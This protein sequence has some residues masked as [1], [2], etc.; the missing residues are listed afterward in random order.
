MRKSILFLL[1]LIFSVLNKLNAQSFEIFGDAFSVPTVSNATCS[2]ADTCF[3]LTANANWQNGAVWDLDPIDLSQAFDATFCMFIGANDQGADGFA[4]VMRDPAANLYGED[5]GSL[6]YGSNDG[7]TGISPSVAIEFDSFYNP[8][9]FDI[10]EDHTA[11]VLNGV[12][13]VA[14]AVPSVPLLPNG[15]NVEDNN[16]HNARIVWNPATQEISMYFDGF[17]RFTYTNDI[18]NNV[19]NG[20]TEVLWGFTASTGGFSNLQQICFPKVLL[21]IPDFEICE[22]DSV[23][24]SY[25]LQNVQ[26][27]TWTNSDGDIIIDWNENMGVPLTQTSFYATE[28]GTYTLTVTF[29]N[30]VYSE[31]ALVTLIPLPEQVSIDLCESGENLN[32]FSLFTTILPTTGTWSGPS[33]LTGNHLGTFNPQTN[34]E[35]VYV[36]STNQTSICP[37]ENQVTINF[38]SINFNPTIDLI[39]C[40]ETVYE[41]EVNPLMS[42]GQTDFTYIWFSTNATLTSN[43]N[44]TEAEI[45]TNS[46]VA[47]QITSND[48]FACEFDTIINLVF[49]S[50]PQFNLGPDIFIC[51][52]ETASIDAF[53]NWDSYLWS[54]NSTNS[55]LTVSSS[56]V[57]WLEVSNDENCVFRDTIEVLVTEIPEITL[58]PFDTISCVPFVLSFEAELTV[59]QAILSWNFGDG[60]SVLNTLS[61]SHTYTS[62]GVYDLTLTASLGSS[63][64]QTLVVE[65]AIHVINRPNASFNYSIIEN[66]GNQITVEFSNNSS[67]YNQFFW[68]FNISSDSIEENPIVTFN[69]VDNSSFTII[70]NVSNGYCEDETSRIIKLPSQ[71]IYYVPNTFTPDGNNFNNVFEPIFTEGILEDSY[72]LSIYNRWG[73][74]VF[75]SF[76]S[77]IGWDGTYGSRIA[78]EGIY[79][80]VIEFLESESKEK[81]QITGHVNLMK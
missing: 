23:L 71:L 1:F 14:P 44:Q 18:I 25:P 75:E 37:N 12:M 2:N 39:P 33:S 7:V 5:G 41:L 3:S 49:Q 76:D 67:F 28:S 63:C 20:N 65:D 57:Y 11:L 79:V 32:L 60:T 34:S 36:Y 81:R 15:A 66:T 54:D 22:Q 35:G 38:Y 21:D 80:W 48:L 17:L 70:L 56:G 42:D 77:K 52:G 6:G 73:E 46:E 72:H 29:N 62:P 45:N 9:F 10:P 74:I 78:K 40:T 64:Q 16:F 27:Y 43:Q 47:L 69:T 55:S 59:P 51:S 19:F 4:F 31:D 24:I 30:V 61:P 58:L 68:D 13:N 26:T 53:G 50:S 8:D